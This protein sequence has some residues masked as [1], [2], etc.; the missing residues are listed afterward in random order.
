MTA[1]MFHIDYSRLLEVM[2][3]IV[4]FAFLLERAM[5]I[6][7][8]H[9]WFMAL[10]Q[11]PPDKP[12]AKKGYKEVIASLVCVAFAWWQDF[13]AVSIIMQ[14]SEKATFWGVVIT[15][16]IIAGGSKASLALFHDLMG[17]MS[18]AE[19][20]RDAANK[21]KQQAI[22]TNTLKEALKP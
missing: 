3:T 5:S 21:A 22:K 11:G 2:L 18:S 13:D 4:V 15:G 14:S 20:E 9:R 7:F 8:E 17:V 16:L 1:D 19:K 10:T 6:L 12:D